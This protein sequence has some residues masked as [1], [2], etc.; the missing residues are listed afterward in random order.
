MDL[1]RCSYHPR[2]PSAARAA[3]WVG[4]AMGFIGRRGKS[5]GIKFKN[6]MAPLA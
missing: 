1:K 2:P 5:P 4:K 3:V 6:K